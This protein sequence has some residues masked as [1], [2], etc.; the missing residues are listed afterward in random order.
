M[1]SNDIPSDNTHSEIPPIYRPSQ[2]P[3]SI[4]IIPI[5]KPSTVESSDT[6][7]GD[8]NISSEMPT[9]STIQK[10]EDTLKNINSIKDELCKLPLD[11]CENQYITNNITP[12]LNVLY[13]LSTSSLSL[14]TSV[15]FLTNSPIVHAKKSELK[16]TL[17]LIYNI[18]DECDDVYDVI[19]KRIKVL[20][21]NC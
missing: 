14:A 15:N 6:K 10:T 7:S 16:E 2:S 20:L 21:D 4:P 1:N 17:H 12:L 9:N 19:K 5:V 13:F 8:E 3:G 11:P 18:N